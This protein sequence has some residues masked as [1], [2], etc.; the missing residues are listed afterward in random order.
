ML[1]EEYIEEVNRNL[2]RRSLKPNQ[3]EHKEYMPQKFVKFDASIKYE[4][5]WDAK[6]KNGRG[7]W[8]LKEVPAARARGKQVEVWDRTA[9]NGRGG[10]VLE[11]VPAASAVRTFARWEPV[12]RRR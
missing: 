6:A 7:G 9:N 5:V 12:R 10:W 11:E 2:E 1:K 8:V 4:K 3:Y